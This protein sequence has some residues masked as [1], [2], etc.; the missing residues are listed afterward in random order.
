MAGETMKE[1]VEKL[2]QL[3][4]EWN[5]EEGTITAWAS[6]AMNELRVQKDLAEKHAE[7]MEVQVV[8]L[9]AELLTVR[10]SQSLTLQELQEDVAVLKKALL[11]T[12]PRTTE[13]APKVRVPEPKGFD[14]TRSAKELEN[15]MWDMEHFLRVAQIA[16]EEKVSITGMYLIGD[17]KIWWRTRLEGDAESGRPQISTWE[18][19]K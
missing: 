3:L 9:K 5:F 6:K 10:E 15:F 7:H 14:G 4:D 16:D 8:S 19:L 1:R 11:Q 13:A 18:T 12:F 17:A 2:E